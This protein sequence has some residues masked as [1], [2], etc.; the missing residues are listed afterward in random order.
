MFVKTNAKLLA[1]CICPQNFYIFI[2]DSYFII[3]MFCF[4]SAVVPALYRCPT[5]ASSSLAPVTCEVRKGLLAGGQGFFL[6]ISH[7]HPLTRFKMIE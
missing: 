2:A 1:L 5:A 3:K 7:F 4:W 6:G